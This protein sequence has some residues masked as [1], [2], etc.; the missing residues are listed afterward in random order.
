MKDQAFTLMELLV[1]ITIIAILIAL[2]L[3]VIGSVRSSAR[4]VGCLNNQ[5]QLYLLMPA[6]AQEHNGMLPPAYLR[7]DSSNGFK[8]LAEPLPTVGT[9]AQKNN[10]I[11]RRINGV[12]GETAYG[13][14]WDS[15]YNYLIPYLPADTNQFSG[16]VW[17][18]K[19]LYKAC[20]LYTSDAADDM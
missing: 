1:T 8:W 10:E 13:M 18:A 5:R 6:Y 3:P 15:W 16:G 9:T 14:C 20:L 7:S 4:A 12:H 17:K 2:V 11:K 19:T